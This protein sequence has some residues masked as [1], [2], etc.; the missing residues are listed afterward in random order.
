M[1][2]TTCNTDLVG[3][4]VAS[5]V[6]GIRSFWKLTA[7]ST[8]L[9][10]L[11]NDTT[12]FG[13][14]SV[15]VGFSS[16]S[17]KADVWTFID[18]CFERDDVKALQQI[19]A[20]K[21]VSGRYPFLL[22]RVM[23]KKPDADKCLAFLTEKRTTPNW[24]EFPPRAFETL[25]TAQLTLMIQHGTVKVDSWNADPEAEYCE[26]LLQRCMDEPRYDLAET[27]VEAGA[28]VDLCEWVRV[29]REEGQTVFECGG[30][31]L[32]NLVLLFDK[33]DHPEKR[34]H[35][36]SLLRRLAKASKDS[37]CFDWKGD[38]ERTALQLA[39][40]YRNE[41]AVKIL[42]EE[43][44]QVEGEVEGT[45]LP[46]LALEGLVA[47]NPVIDFECAATLRELAG[48]GGVDFCAMNAD[49]HTPLSLACS[50][51]MEQSAEVL[52]KMGV[53][54]IKVKKRNKTSNSPL[55]EAL[56][57]HSEPVVSLLLRW[58]AD[59]NEV[60]KVGGTAYT[61]LQWVLIT[62]PQSG[63]E[64]SVSL[65]TVLLQNGAHCPLSL[66]SLPIPED[67]GGVTLC[68][69]PCLLLACKIKEASEVVRLL[70]EK[71]GADPNRLEVVGGKSYTLLQLVLGACPGSRVL[72]SPGIA[73]VLLNRGVRCPFSSPSLIASQK[74]ESAPL[75][76][77]SPLLLACRIQDEQ[78]VH[79]LCEKGGADPNEV[80]SI[81]G[82]AY[83]LLQLV[84]GGGPS[85]SMPTSPAVAKAL[86][87]NGARC[88][89]SPPSFLQSRDLRGVSL[90]P[91]SCL[92]LACQLEEDATE[93]VHLLCD[94]GGANPNEVVK[95]EGTT[96]TLLQLVLGASCE[97]RVLISPANA[98]ALVEK[99]ARCPSST[100]PEDF[101]L[102]TLWMASRLEEA[103][104][105]RLLCEK[106]GADP[107]EVVVV[108]GHR[109]TLLQLVLGA[110]PPSC[111][112]KSLT[113]AKA[114]LQ[115][116]ARCPFSS[117]LPHFECLHLVPPLLLVCRTPE[118]D[119][120]LVHLLCER[121]RANP[122]M[123]G[124][125][126]GLYAEY[127]VIAVTGSVI[128]NMMDVE[129][130][131]ELLQALE[132]VGGDLNVIGEDGHD[133]EAAS[134]LLDWGADPN[135]AGMRVRRE[136]WLKKT[137]SLTQMSPLQA[138]MDRAVE[139]ETSFWQ[140]VR[141]AA[142]L[143][144]RGARDPEGGGDSE[145]SS[146][147]APAAASFWSFFRGVRFSP[148]SKSGS[149]L[150]DVI[151]VEKARS[152]L[153]LRIIQE[154]PLEEL[155]EPEVQVGV[156]EDEQVWSS[157]LAGGVQR[158]GDFS[159]LVVAIQEKWVEGVEVLLQRGVQVNRRNDVSRWMENPI[160][161]TPLFAALNT[162]QWAL[163]QCLLQKGAEV[164]LAEGEEMKR[165]KSSLPA[166][167]VADPATFGIARILIDD[168]D[169]FG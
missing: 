163:A 99:G 155:M 96:Y 133:L 139:D 113:V 79:L 18:E 156:K 85:S 36:L 159:P 15:C 120:E 86:L 70:C 158:V 83:T 43:Q 20:L 141:V 138:V 89:L 105:V 107:N 65:A 167:I 119:A 62:A 94:Q 68:S 148:L 114:L 132:D 9:L 46:F 21:G 157:F 135:Q 5:G 38:R 126:V 72:T 151:S 143:I 93:V 37:G 74:M 153:L 40:R 78:T 17:E 146:S 51:K 84:L 13:F 116:G 134:L 64:V 48:L 27:L 32:Q 92:V 56:K 123:R 16:P 166:D 23:D 63:P 91:L 76:Q 127:P 8:E 53:G 142:L 3:I 11:R 112:P 35:S 145:S 52:L 61:P 47:T 102:S 129:K 108:E 122:N 82:R 144:E 55:F 154:I 50:L 161:Q 101:G 100:S 160:P 71:G 2:H 69:V 90:C 66:P 10:S 136:D 104:V 54:T 131:V 7:V 164:T 22:K 81:E 44:V 147:S 103:N 29:E 4:L 162:E 118:S 33:E 14:G 106:G 165:R 73:K 98:I 150:A 121:G 169:Q 80:V 67:L 124:P 97:S 41:E 57:A 110:G 34:K 6:L 58:K 140:I 125:G 75:C 30:T 60:E 49:V 149:W 128:N 168:D 152:P 137:L 28:R 31:P 109:Y 117:P 59:P 87:Q 42:V 111:M 45:R 130:G 24:S 115:G 26:T 88:P 12:I 1:S 19:L 95:I 25:T 77:L 39:C